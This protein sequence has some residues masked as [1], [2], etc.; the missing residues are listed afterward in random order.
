MTL[1]RVMVVD[2][3]V[4]RRQQIS[5]LV[6][7]TRLATVCGVAN[8]GATAIRALRSLEPDVITLDLEM[9]GVDGFAF[10]RLMMSTRPT[11]VIVVSSND[12]RE[13]V[14]KALELGASDFI[15]APQG[16]IDEAVQTTLSQKLLSM[17]AV[18]S[19]HLSI[20]PAQTLLPELRRLP[21]SEVR[22]PKFLVAL[23][24]STGGP[25]AITNVLSRL[26]ATLD[27]AVLIAQHMP[28]TFT[29]T[30]AERLDRYSRLDVR[31][32]DDGDPVGAGMAL[33]CPGSRS[34]EVSDIGGQ[35]RVRVRPPRPEERYTP[36]VTRLMSS[37]AKAYGARAIGVVMTGMGD[38]GSEGAR[39]I[40][41]AG[42][43]VFV[44]GESTAIVYGMPR[45]ALAVAPQSITVALDAIASAI[46][47]AVAH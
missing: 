20:A 6:E 34:M 14:F 25:S 40:V 33:I 30:F 26:P 19:E 3:S 8:N 17:R 42:G 15:S 16:S 29:G 4:T 27:C 23:G 38:D 39:R 18:R 44:E 35:L 31:E 45:A 32:A 5:A 22:R 21:P 13:N 12:K 37:V 9:P 10:L 24:A 7:A 36:S 41:K 11:P 47:R 43:K 46:E 28:G 2:D 1:L